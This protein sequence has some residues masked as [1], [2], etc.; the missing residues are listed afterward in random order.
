MCR[1]GNCTW[2]PVATLA[3]RALC[4]DVTSSIQERCERREDSSSEMPYHNCT[5]SLPNGASA[6]YTNGYQTEAIALKVQSSSQPI[7]YTNAT[8]PVIKRI[9]A[10]VASAEEGSTIAQN[11]RD[12]PRYVAT[13]CSLEPIVRSIKASVNNSEYHE[14]I[15]AEWTKVEAWDD[16]ETSSHGYSLLPNW[17]E[18]LGAYP[19]QNFTLSPKAHD[20]I[21]IF[22]KALFSG[23]AFTSMMRL[24]FRSDEVLSEA[25]ATADVM[26]AF[27]YGNVT[28]CAD[29]KNNRFSCTMKNVADAMTKSFRDQEY[30][31]S[32]RE[33]KMAVGHTQVNVTMIH[34]RW[35]WLTLPL[36]VWLLGAVTWLGTWWKTRR[37]N[38]QRWSDNPLPLLFL[39]RGEEDMRANE[40]QGVSIQ[41]YERRAKSIR[42]HLYTEKNRAEFVE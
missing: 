24:A 14:T 9:E 12:D 16:Y 8:L 32:K 11:I 34:V 30:L 7:M 18:N 41:A 1:T 15:L 39:Y 5:V 25:Y 19:G 22:M 2:D 35:Q 33:P 26:Q 23:D 42:A 40:G 13:E 29:N 38:V 28:G 37:G 6:Y 20:T 36:F 17:N 31:N 10:V 27:M 21:S 4:S 3:V